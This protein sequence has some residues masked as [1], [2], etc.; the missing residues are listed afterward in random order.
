MK[1]NYKTLVDIELKE[2]GE[3]EQKLIESIL[4][5]KDWENYKWWCEKYLRGFLL[6]NNMY[7]KTYKVVSY[8]CTNQTVAN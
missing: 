2:E 5:E 1:E 4:K 7:P 6:D 8:R 3:W